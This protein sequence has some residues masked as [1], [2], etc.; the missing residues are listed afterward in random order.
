MHK[1]VDLEQIIEHFGLKPLPVEGGIFTQ[2]Y[3]ATETIPHHAL[4]ERY[5]TD[6]PLGTAIYYFYTPDFNSFSA[7]HM[8]P[9]DE[10]YHFY[11]GDPI[12]MLFLHPDGK[13]ERVIL[14]QDILNGQKV[15]HVAPRGVW[16]GSHMPHGGKFA[17][18]GT[19][20]A[21][22]FTN[23]DYLGGDRDE[24]IKQFPH[25]AELITRLT[26]PD[27]PLVMPDDH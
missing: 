26:R 13:S 3:C 24:L 12:E 5:T 23:G 9:T 19:T 15:Q 7:L 11:L 22:G 21:P 14:G 6:K 4:P 27:E 8:L 17:L 25:E 2:S 1:N 18:V 20:M 16:H 10:I